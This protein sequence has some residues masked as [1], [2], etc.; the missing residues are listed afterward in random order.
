[1]I[2]IP[3][4]LDPASQVLQGLSLGR[5]KIS[6]S[7]S[8]SIGP[9]FHEKHMH[10]ARKATAFSL[11]LDSATT[12]R[13]GLSK[14]LD[15]HIIFWDKEHGQVMDHLLKIVEMT[16]ETADVLKATLLNA[17]DEEGLIFR[18][19]LAISRD[20]PNVN[21]ALMKLLVQEAEQQ[22]SKLV[23]FGSCVLHTAHNAFKQGLRDLSV[24]VA[25]L[26]KCLHGF[27]KY[28][29]I[30]REQF[31][32]ELLDIEETTEA[33]LR[34][35]DTRWLSLQPALERIDKNWTAICNYFLRTLPER[36]N[37]GSKNEKEALGTQYYKLIKTELEKSTCQ[38][39]LKEVIF[40]C[41]KF[42]P[43]LLALQSTEP[44]IHLLHD[45]CF[46][47]L[48][49]VSSCLLKREHLPD[50]LTTRQLAK[51]DLNK[52]ET[53]REQPK[54]SPSGQE[55]FNKLPSNTRTVVKKEFLTM[56]KKVG[57]YLQRNLHP[58]D[59]TLV[60][61]LR[62]LE[63]QVSKGLHDGGTEKVVKAAR[64]LGRFS[65]GEVDSLALQWDLL[66]T[67]SLEKKG[68]ER[69]DNYY[70]RALAELKKNGS[71]VSLLEKF[72]HLSLSLPTSNAE[73]ER[74]FSL[75]KLL[76]D[77]RERLSLQS[78]FAQRVTKEVVTFYGGAE[79]VPITPSLVA[80]HASARYK[81]RERIEKEQREKKE[82]EKEVVAE[83][84][85]APKRQAEAEKKADYEAKKKRYNDEETSLREQLKF[86]E[87]RLTEI[88][89]RAE[90]TKNIEELRS[91]MAAQKQLRE[92]LKVKRTKL[93]GVIK[94][95]VKLLESHAQ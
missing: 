62:V 47:L 36:A 56:F 13:G 35:I 75:S 58:L 37:E 39:V 7:I 26:A 40:M 11:A 2:P 3:K 89:S 67:M 38:V 43:F 17:L 83:R 88:E 16:T 1:M 51:L 92:A 65:P 32:L 49:E 30:R 19:V 78:L 24:D 70:A 45:R 21:K 66:T 27:F 22:G 94:K 14:D 29:T 73:V 23:D 4:Q 57:E 86:D 46:T 72:V 90:K 61:H 87:I 48:L 74:G 76:L 80:S 81:Y 59:S 82:F 85:Q 68:G 93:D 18:N 77:S 71:E 91:S 84:E 34:H 95:K 20:N 41:Q 8:D 31:A 28:S 44:Q 79:N 69:I 64:E 12:K 5:Q 54:M 53:W 6:Y 15:I 55:C 60:Q 33:F 42:A 50:N 63:P 9:F 25:L 52:K 10:S